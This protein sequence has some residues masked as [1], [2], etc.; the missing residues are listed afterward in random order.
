MEELSLSKNVANLR[1]KKGVTQETLAEFI[2]VTKASVSKWE[3]GQSMP[4]VLILPKLASFFDVSVDELLGYHPQLTKE[5]IR[6]FYQQWTTAFS[7]EPFEYVM[8]DCRKAVKQYYSCYP[9][10]LQVVVLWLN[11]FMLTKDLEEQQVILSEAEALCT[12][13]VEES[14]ELS[15]CNNA[16]LLK[17]AVMLQL[18]KPEE[19]LSEIEEKADPYRFAQQS[20][21]LLIQAYRAAGQTKKAVSYTQFSM[22]SHLIN[23]VSSATHYLLIQ[24]IQLPV[25]EETVNRIDAVIQAFNL[26]AVHPNSCAQFS[27]AA[28]CAY[29]KHEKEEQV[30]KCLKQFVDLTLILLSEEGR[31]LHGDRYFDEITEIFEGADLGVQQIRDTK[32]IREGALSALENPIFQQIER[33]KIEKLKKRLAGE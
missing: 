33:S 22:F 12:K 31:I 17:V 23:L 24:I 8:E 5:Q 7:E 19:A 32:I 28:A 6:H 21:T 27:Y 1:K 25:I 16:S 2:G 29:A 13:I 9:F 18:G 30:I 15:L 3:T 4:D 11:H 20:D 14:T 10:L 26:T